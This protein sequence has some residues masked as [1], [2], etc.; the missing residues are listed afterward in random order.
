M[1]TDAGAF[2]FVFHTLIVLKAVSRL[3]GGGG[4]GGRHL[5]TPTLQQRSGPVSSGHIVFRASESTEGFIEGHAFS[6][7]YDLA[8]R[9]F[10]PPSSGRKLDWRHTERLRKRNNWVTGEGEGVGE[11]PDHTIARKTGPL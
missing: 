4:R 10:L 5:T 8:P 2:Y 1:G 11:E 6:Q 9:P 3:E 7:S